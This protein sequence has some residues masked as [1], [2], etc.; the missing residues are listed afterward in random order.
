MLQ[1]HLVSVLIASAGENESDL[2]S[3]RRSLSSVPVS[4]FF[5]KNHLILA[6]VEWDFH[7]CY[8]IGSG[9][10]PSGDDHPEGAPS[11]RPTGAPSWPDGYDPTACVG[12]GASSGGMNYDYPCGP[13][14]VERQVP[15]GYDGP[16]SARP[17]CPPGS[18]GVFVS[19]PDGGGS[20]LGSGGGGGG[21]E[22]SPSGP[23]VRYI[24]NPQE[25]ADQRALRRARRG[26]RIASCH[27]A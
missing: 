3:C 12:T 11:S 24:G 19:G 6:M 20:G 8:M 1:R 22:S 2:Q 23:G 15:V 5:G 13:N 16:D 17:P 7:P 9:G 10:T 4:M 18:P 27:S 14:R 21:G 25:D 26:F